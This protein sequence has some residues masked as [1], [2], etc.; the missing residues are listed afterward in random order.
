MYPLLCCLHADAD[1]GAA[2]S[3][4]GGESVLSQETDDSKRVFFK[5]ISSGGPSSELSFV[6]DS[7]IWGGS[8]SASVRLF[9][10]AVRQN[11]PG[12]REESVV[13][14]V[15]TYG[16]ISLRLSIPATASVG[17][18]ETLQKLVNEGEKLEIRSTTTLIA[19]C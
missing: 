7:P 8:D 11:F 3:G 5:D 19:K 13:P 12:L 10:N 17:V 1:A 16:Q 18:L 4:G 2:A 14:N 9:Q 15:N 6:L